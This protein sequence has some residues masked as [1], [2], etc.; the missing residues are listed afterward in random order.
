MIWTP[1]LLGAC[2]IS[3]LLGFVPRL[4]QAPFVSPGKGSALAMLLIFLFAG[5]A[6][7][8]F[9]LQGQFLSDAKNHRRPGAGEHRARALFAHSMIHCG[10][11]CLVTGS[12]ILGLAELT[13]HAATD[14]AKCDGRIT[15]T[16][17]QAIHYACKVAWAVIAW[18]FL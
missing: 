6:V 3:G 12:V 5:H 16:Q 15:S 13:I 1:M 8:D 14:Y 9:P 10:M 17:D 2:H 4:V 18:R 7:C 11:V